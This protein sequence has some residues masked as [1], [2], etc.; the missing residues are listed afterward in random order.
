MPVYHKIAGMTVAGINFY[1]RFSFYFGRFPCMLHK[2]KVSN[3]MNTIT[4]GSRLLFVINP[5][6]GNSE[7][8]Y[9]SVIREFFSERPDFTITSYQLGESEDDCGRLQDLIAWEKPDKVIATGGDGTIKMVAELLLGTDMPMGIL[10]AGS[11]N[12]MAKELEI[13]TEPG[14]ALEKILQGETKRIHLLRVNKELC[15]HLS[16]VGFNAALV[17]TFD[18]MG[19][20]GM[21]GY[22]KAGWRVLWRH[23]PMTAMFRFDGRSVQ[24]DAVMIVLANATSYG[25]G[26]RINP[27]GRLDDELFEIVI[28]K[29]I[30]LKELLKMAFLN[31]AFDPA[32]T[33]VFQ[34]TGIEIKA[35]KK[36]H[37]QVDGEYIGK[38]SHVKAELLPS[39]I[40]VIC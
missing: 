35:R 38:V 22:I 6:S 3:R 16:D 33:E 27:E 21:W 9:P 28:V 20:R 1:E 40:S 19:Q 25:T 5:G 36:V 30:S 39:A 11:A 37:F 26:L 2:N 29:K 15:I 10:P 4:P 24:R 32:K 34:T 8:D 7:T 14:A 12:G 23:A 17:K 18:R 13:P 31:I